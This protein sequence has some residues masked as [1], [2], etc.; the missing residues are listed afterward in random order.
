MLVTCPLVDVRAAA[1]DLIKVAV[2]KCAPHEDYS[3]DQE[4][5]EVR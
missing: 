4:S 1:S 5:A 2:A 3:V